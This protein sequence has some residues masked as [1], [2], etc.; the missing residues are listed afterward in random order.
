MP[1][2]VESRIPE[3]IVEAETR[4]RENV[5]RTSEEVAVDARLN[6]TL[7][8]SIVSGELFES[9][10]AGEEDEDGYVGF[11]SAG[12]GLPDAR[13]VYIELGTGVRGSRYEFPGKPQDVTYD[14]EWER[15]IPKDMGFAYLIP[16]MEAEREPFEERMGDV[17]G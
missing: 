2:V 12:E 8:G 10:H 13:A 15:G 14:M 5:A 11:A 6:L 3:I 1:V 16:A 4:A 17:Y 7:H 9:V